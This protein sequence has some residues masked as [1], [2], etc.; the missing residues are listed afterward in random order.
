MIHAAI[1]CC[2]NQHASGVLERR[3]RQERIREDRYFSNA[4]QQISISCRLISSLLKFTIFKQHCGSRGNITRNEFRIARLINLNS[5]EHLTYQD[6]Q[7]LRR[8]LMA[9][10]RIHVQDIV[11]D[12]TLSCFYTLV[13]QQILQVQR[14]NC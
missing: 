6:L 7:V 11:H 12:I 4:K 10:C 1:D 8:N 9:L 14:T 3:C 13:F 5:R 2:I